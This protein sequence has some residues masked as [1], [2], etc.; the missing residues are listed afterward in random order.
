VEQDQNL[1]EDVERQQPDGKAAYH[2]EPQQTANQAKIQPASLADE[3]MANWKQRWIG[4]SHC[5]CGS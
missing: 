1:G 4:A 3:A 5:I 2:N